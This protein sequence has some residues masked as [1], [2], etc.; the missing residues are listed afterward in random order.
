[1]ED[2]ILVAILFTYTLQLVF[3]RLEEELASI[4]NWDLPIK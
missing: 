1:M 2:F 3:S 4:T